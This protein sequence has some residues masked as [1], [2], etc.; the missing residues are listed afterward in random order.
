MS[1]SIGFFRYRKAEYGIGHTISVWECHFKFIENLFNF[2][3]K[4][5]VFA[6][7]NMK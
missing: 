1:N 2:K 7:A 5:T 6:I 3:A 4:I